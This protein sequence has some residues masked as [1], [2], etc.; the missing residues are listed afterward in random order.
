MQTIKVMA[1]YECHPLW[2]VDDV[3]ARNLSPRELRVPEDLILDLENWAKRY[4]ATLDWDDP[5]SSGFASEDEHR[6]WVTQGRALASRLQLELGDGF[7]VEYFDD[8]EQRVVAVTRNG[9]SPE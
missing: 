8:L 6:S 4:D 9:P 3:P 2:A 7:R 5:A 1:D